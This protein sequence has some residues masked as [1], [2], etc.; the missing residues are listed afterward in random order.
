MLVLRLE[1]YFGMISKDWKR[2]PEEGSLNSNGLN[3]G[4]NTAARGLLWS[5]FD[6][7]AASKEAKA[8]L[9][10]IGWQRIL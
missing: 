6:K 8:R 7:K 9:D 2:L 5:L 1:L 10:T 4:L 3:M